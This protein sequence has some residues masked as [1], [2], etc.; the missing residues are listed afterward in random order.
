[1]DRDS[2]PEAVAGW[3]VNTEVAP[4]NLHLPDSYWSVAPVVGLSAGNGRFTISY[5]YYFT[6]VN[7]NGR[8]VPPLWNDAD[9]IEPKVKF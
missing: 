6:S 9:A 8:N 4:Q 1:M 3:Q 7:S 5:R 2:W